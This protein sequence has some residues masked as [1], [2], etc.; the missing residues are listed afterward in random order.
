V[1]KFIS[2]IIILT[3]ILH[4][5]DD[6]VNRL[7]ER[8]R[9]F[10][11][12][13]L[14]LNLSIDL[15]QQTVHGKEAFTFHPL[16][17]EFT[18]LRLH[19]EDTEIKSVSFQ[20][21]DLVANV[22]SGILTITFPKAL[23]ISDTATLAIEYVASPHDG[24]HFFKPTP[25]IPAIPYQVWS[26]G[27]G[28]GNRH[29]FPAYDLPDDKVTT[30][31]TVT[32]PKGMISV[33]NG[34]LLDTKVMADG[35]SVQH[36]R[37]AQPQAT[38]LTTLIIGDFATVK[39]EVS[40][41]T[42]EYNVPREWASQTEYFFGK[43]PSILRF[44]SDYIFPYPY[45]RY[46]QTTVW[47]F[48]FGGMENTTATTMNRRLLYSP[49]A[50]PNYTGHDLVAHE[51]AHQW[52]GDM[53]TCKTWE[54]IWLNEGFATYF[55]TLWDGYVAGVD[56]YE[57]QIFDMMQTYRSELI[58]KDYN[59]SALAAK[60]APP[61]LQDDKAYHGGAVILHMLRNVVGDKNFKD[62]IRQYIRSHLYGNVVTED[63]IADMEKVSGKSLKQFS[64]NW[65]YQAN[66]PDFHV[67]GSYDSL[68]GDYWLTVNQP[69]TA[70]R[71]FLY[72]GALPFRLEAKSFILD[73]TLEIR[74]SN[75]QF[76]FR[77]PHTPD[78]VYFN[79]RSGI[80]CRETF[81]QSNEELITKLRYSESAV[82]RLKAVQS[83]MHQPAIIYR[84][85]GAAFR[86]EDNYKIRSE[87]VKLCA[88]QPTAETFEIIKTATTDLDPRVRETAFNEL[89]HFAD[90]G[91]IHILRD[92]I[93]GET[94][95]YCKAA[96]YRSY[97][98]LHPADVMHFLAGAMTTDSHRNIVRRAV[99]ES[100]G[101]QNDDRALPFASAMVEYNFGSGDLHHVELAALEY[102]ARFVEK[103][104]TGV[105]PIIL[106]GIQNPYFRTRNAA[107]G[108]IERFKLS[109]A[110]QQ[111]EKVLA[112]ETRSIVKPALEKA[113]KV[114]K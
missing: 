37:M 111:L 50:M 23:S 46:A 7:N 112:A 19:T 51:F 57:T 65:L 77:V 33:S 66:I 39:E 56:E 71:A 53:V 92:K 100:L 44:F 35:S 106:K 114:I 108:L 49:S 40:G 8:S 36:W 63:F 109:E 6:I 12:I 78:A 90:F 104:R 55:T 34:D 31:L 107:A 38:Y 88:Q 52:W 87:I 10:D 47:D 59:D 93:A 113:L 30:D 105:L 28:T 27:E 91:A 84:P 81:P 75:E 3:G 1:K 41:V 69:D 17:K 18:T 62:G 102:C 29:W 61:A 86:T 101:E 95:D 25:E 110:R 98:K 16:V 72:K 2:A 85:I 14:D 21:L 5:Q 20:G 79:Y 42:L 68:T 58:E 67:T 32:V 97:G 13:H 89:S 103:N 96:I 76:R 11:Q 24:L 73:T 82:E 70:K 15:H 80:V 83:L 48:L 45:K 43:T 9:N 94:N 64:S 60:A 22:D 54:H 74:H 26:Q 4:A 99:F